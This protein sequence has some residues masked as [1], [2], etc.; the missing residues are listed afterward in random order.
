MDTLASVSQVSITSGRYRRLIM[1]VMSEASSAIER[2]LRET[3]ARLHE[4]IAAKDLE[5]TVLWALLEGERASRR[6]HELRL[7]DLKRRLSMN[8]ANSSTPPSKESIAAKAKRKTER[9]RSQRE[10]SKDRKPGGQTGHR[11]MGLEP[12][13]GD[14]IDDTLTTEAAAECSGCG[15]DLGEHEVA[16]GRSWGQVWEIAPIRLDKVHWLPPRT[17]CD[18]CAKVT[19]ATPP[20]GPGPVAYR[21][22]LKSAALLLRFF[23]N[24][25]VQR[26]AL[27]ME[28]LLGVKV[29]AGFVARTAERFDARLTEAGFEEALKAAL[30]AEDVLCGDESPVNVLCKDTDERTGEPKTEQPHAVV[31]RTP[32]ERLVWLAPIGSRTKD[33]LRDLGVLSGWHGTS[34][35]DD[36]KGWHQFD[37]TLGDVQQCAAHLIRQ[38]QGVA[39]LHPTWQ[40]W[41][42]EV[43]QVL[44]EANTAVLDADLLAGPRP[45]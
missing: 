8:S 35:R 29:P 5:I 14:D 38:L 17:R 40:L 12:A 10:Q 2:S 24:V 28:A 31:L 16:A 41:A 7:A 13:R 45:L 33:D 25:P 42:V 36:C 20:F 39:D 21:P 34:V 9:Q 6:D 32:D 4:V 19:T 22:N 15:A 30:R 26:T 44:R 23:G 27:V 37:A 1:V 3:I 11:G 18:C 43:Q